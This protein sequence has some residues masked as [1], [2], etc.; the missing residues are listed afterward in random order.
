M[1]WLTT[2]L[3]LHALDL[4][5][6][7]RGWN[8]KERTTLMGRMAMHPFN[9]GRSLQRDRRA[10]QV[11]GIQLA[12][13]MGSETLPSIVILIGYQCAW[14]GAL[15]ITSCYQFIRKLTYS[16]STQD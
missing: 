13:V 11:M 3:I 4:Q 15:M 7:R 12:F 1:G 10:A 8:L 2:V 14:P 6:G 9:R 16:P 5:R